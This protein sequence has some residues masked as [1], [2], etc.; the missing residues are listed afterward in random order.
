MTS[1]PEAPRVKG[2]PGPKPNPDAVRVQIM[3]LRGK[4]AWGEWLDR[5]AAFRGVDKTELV[6]KALAASAMACGFEPPPER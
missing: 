6:E 2:R 1:A 5:Y 4:K 3:Q